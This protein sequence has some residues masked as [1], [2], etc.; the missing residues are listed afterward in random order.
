MDLIKEL[1][2]KTGAGIMDAKKILQE[3]NGDIE[4]AVAEMRK[5]GQKIAAKKSDR[6][7]GEGLVECYAHSTGKLASVVELACETD[8]VARND[9]F[10]ALAHDLAMHVAGA[11]PAYLAKED[12]PEDVLKK[13]RDLV[14]EQLKAEGKPEDMLEKIAEGKLQKF[15]EEVCL[16]EQPF[17]KDDKKKVGDV[18]NE[19]VAKLGENLVIRRFERWVLGQ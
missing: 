2:A 17:I 18:L 15:Y 16:L 3:T 6:A 19:A 4:K 13:E 7:T 11:S 8:F 12:V 1:R 10:K 14:M 5:R 9:E